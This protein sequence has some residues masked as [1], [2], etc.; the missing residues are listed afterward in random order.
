MTDRVVRFGVKPLVFVASLGPLAWLVWAAVTG[1]LSANPLSDLTNETG[2]W[3]IR[4][5]CITLAMTPM[6]RLTGWNGLAK[7][8]RM[9]G[10]YA[11]FYG[12]LHFLTY[13]VV[14]R[15]AGL[16][17][18]DGIVSSTTAVGLA[19]SVGADILERP[20]ITIGFAAWSTM[21]PLAITSTVGWIRRLGGRN[22]NRLH[23]LVYAT[24]IA[25][26]LHYWWLVRSDISRPFA[27][28]AVVL[29]LLAFRAQKLWVSG[30][31]R[32]A[33]ASCLFVFVA[34][35]AHAAPAHPRTID[36]AVAA[37]STVSDALLN[38]VFAEADAIWAQADVAFHWRRSSD[39][40]PKS[41]DGL[42]LI[43]E[44][45]GAAAVGA[46]APLGW[47]TFE[48]GH[49]GHTIHLAPAN[50]E[51]LIKRTPAAHDTTFGEHEAL[52]GRAMGRAFAHE[53]GHYL[54]KSKAHAPQGLMRA[55]WPA[56]EFLSQDR[57]RFGLPD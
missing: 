7:F 33:M 46:E 24:G 18:P 28:A 27:Y 53:A 30:V 16:N 6:R 34:T 29:G 50:V 32:T 21:L 17:F 44:R 2:V 45:P 8:R 49:P 36:V 43:L 20:F 3:T 39:A 37:P 51:S 26:V 40:Q 23:K 35:T 57:A 19:R 48:L 14:D 11:F 10:L 56:E 9:T 52:L 12:T 4:F 55:A 25:A 15:F 31:T 5:V 42:I 22:W 47:I 54:L 1:N 38:D 41:D 13:I